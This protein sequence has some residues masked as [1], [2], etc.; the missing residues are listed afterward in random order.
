MDSIRIYKFDNLRCFLLFLV[1]L[2]HQFQSFDGGVSSVLC[3]TIYVFHIPALLFISGIFA[4]RHFDLNKFMNTIIFPYWIMQM[5]YL[6]FYI[7]VMKNYSEQYFKPVWLL[8]YLMTLGTYYLFIPILRL[9][10]TK[11]V[12]VLII[13]VLLS[14]GVGYIK[15]IGYPFSLGRTFTFLPFFLFGFYFSDEIKKKEFRKNQGYCLLGVAFVVTAFWLVYGAIDVKMLYGSYSYKG[16][17]TL[18]T[19]ASQLILSSCW[20]LGLVCVMPN[21]EINLVSALGKNTMP[22]YLFH[23]ILTLLL[24]KYHWYQ[25][26]QG[27]NIAIAVGVSV[28]MVILLGGI[29]FKVSVEY[30]KDNVLFRK[31][32]KILLNF[33]P[34]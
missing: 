23:G 33:K 20:I 14:L 26:S 29:K 13:A 16:V 21:R 18:W 28:V 30:S 5:V 19:R 6:M 15:S 4:S 8:W 3:R 12:I 34:A 7:Y 25:F 17:Y 24:R 11:K 2:G 9:L 32:K 22:I 27:I 1:V 31:L 10:Q